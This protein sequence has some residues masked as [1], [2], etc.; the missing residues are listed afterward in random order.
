VW[1]PHG[2]GVRV[3]WRLV[4]ISVGRRVDQGHITAT[5]APWPS[6]AARLL[7]VELEE[8]PQSY[9]IGPTGEWYREH[10][11][12]RGNDQAG[13]HVGGLAWH[14]GRGKEVGPA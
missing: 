11:R 10:A 7:W 13:P 3:S 14:C 12:I 5:R 4:R 8:A 1:D 6:V 9:G 2:R